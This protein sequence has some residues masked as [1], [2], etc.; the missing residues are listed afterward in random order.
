MLKKLLPLFVI[1]NLIFVPSIAQQEFTVMAY[2]ILNFQSTDSDRV[3]YFKTVVESVDPDILVLEELNSES[4][5]NL[6]RN[7]VLNG[8]YATGDYIPNSTHFVQ[9][10]CYKV[11][12]FKFISNT[13]ISTDVRD[14]NEFKLVSIETGDTL[15]IYG[16]HLKAGSSDNDRFQRNYE[17]QQLRK[18]TDKLSVDQDYLIVGDFNFYGADEPAYNLLQN[19]N[20]TQNGYV[21]DPLVMPGTWNSPAYAQHHTQSPRK[22]SFGGGV[23]GGMDDRFDLI[24]YSHSID[25]PGGLEYVDNSTWAVGNDGQ[26]YNDSVNEMPNSSVSQDVANA[27]H[28][29]SDHLPITAKFKY[30]P[31][32]VSENPEF[33]HVK[34]FPNPSKNIVQIKSKDYPISQIKVSNIF[35]QE[36][37]DQELN[38]RESQ[39]DLSHFSPGIYFFRLEINGNFRE[40]KIIRE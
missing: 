22:R 27:L 34:L 13:P 19:I 36:L 38:D 12:K 37:I 17:I 39:I 26:H 8:F 16:L 4:A 21:V 3:G 11:N 32:G 10:I 35:G 24:L 9:A 15:R 5:L 30:M 1:S 29:G 23:T 7:Q 6:F 31:A 2:N 18:V 28:Y 40:Y 33:D 14:I 25:L 20:G